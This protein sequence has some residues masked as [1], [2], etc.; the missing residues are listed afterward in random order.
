LCWKLEESSERE[1]WDVFCI[2]EKFKA[3]NWKAW[4]CQ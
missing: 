1:C 2:E 3:Q 4:A